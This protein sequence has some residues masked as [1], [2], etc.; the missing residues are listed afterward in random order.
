MGPLSTNGTRSLERKSLAQK[1]TPY[2][3]NSQNCVERQDVNSTPPPTHN[4]KARTVSGPQNSNAVLDTTGPL[5]PPMGRASGPLFSEAPEPGDHGPT[6]AAQANTMLTTPLG[7]EY[8][9]VSPR[10]VG[11]DTPWLSTRKAAEYL[12]LS[13]RTLEDYRYRGGGPRYCRAHQRVRYHREEH[14]DAWLKE[15]LAKNT[16]EE[17]LHGRLP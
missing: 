2:T 10:I 11:A 8:L 9:G 17:R 6:R 4:T 7:A 14:L 5:V 12:G 1:A 13:P 3:R 15:S 16:T